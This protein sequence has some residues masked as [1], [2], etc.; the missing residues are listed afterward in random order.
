MFLDRNGTQL[1]SCSDEAEGREFLEANDLQVEELVK[2]GDCLFAT[3]NPDTNLDQFYTWR[4][5]LPGSIPMKELWRPFL[6]STAEES[7]G[8]NEFLRGVELA[9]GHSVYS[10]ITLR[11]TTVSK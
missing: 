6:W 11:N 4:E 3:V 7:W 9:P 10:L 2:V 1:L 8:T 5:V